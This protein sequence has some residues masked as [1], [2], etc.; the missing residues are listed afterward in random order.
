M[1]SIQVSPGQE[2]LESRTTSAKLVSIPWQLDHPVFALI[3]AI[4]QY[5]TKDMKLMGCVNDGKDFEAF[6]K[7]QLQVPS[8]NIRTLYDKEAT[9]SNILAG[10]N[11]YLIG[12]KNIKKDDLIFFF[13]AGH[14]DS[15][16][17]PEGWGSDKGK[18]EAIC[19]VDISAFETSNQF[20]ADLKY[21]IP[22]WTFHA[23]MRLLAHEKGNNIV[24]IFDCCHSGGLARGLP[25]LADSP[26]KSRSLL[27]CRDVPRRL[28]LPSNLDEELCSRGPQ[29]AETSGG[30]RTFVTPFGFA[31]SGSESHVLLA[32]CQTGEKA[33][34]HRPANLNID[35]GRFTFHLM[36]Y[37][38]ETTPQLAQSLTYAGLMEHVTRC[39][40]HGNSQPT[41]AQSTAVDGSS[42]QQPHCEGRYK[43]RILFSTGEAR[44]S[45][46]F[47][48]TYDHSARALYVAAG[49]I[50]G[51]I[52][53]D[54][55]TMTRFVCRQPATA[56]NS[57][58]T[59]ITLVPTKVGPFRTV[60]TIPDAVDGPPNA[61]AL[62][63]LHGLNA[64]VSSWGS[65]LMKV[66]I[67]GEIP[68]HIGSFSLVKT[69][70]SHHADIS[71]ESEPEG[72][73]GY[74][75]TRYDPL[76]S[77]FAKQTLALNGDDVRRDTV[78]H[79]IAKFNFNLYRHNPDIPVMDD[80]ELS[81][82]VQ[83]RPLQI[84]VH[85][86]T[87]QLRYE[88]EGSQDLFSNVERQII[89]ACPQSTYHVRGNGVKEAIIQA[90]EDK[91]YGLTL[92]TS[93]KSESQN[94]P[95]MSLFPYVFY[96]DPEDYSITRLYAPE[97]PKQAPLVRAQGQRYQLDIG[98]GA[99]STRCLQFPLPKGINKASAFLKIFVSTE[100]IDMDGLEQ[101]P[102]QSGDNR[103]PTFGPVDLGP[104]WSSSVYVLTTC[105]FG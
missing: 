70:P 100:Y 61:T 40:T 103:V 51:V 59:E 95:P 85:R 84:A 105:R 54:D 21:G 67:S 26:M 64:T 10:F 72:H 33:R 16:D 99:S 74:I 58:S 60:V 42:F 25:N 49:S 30:R 81:I 62:Q 4:D 6:L 1:A 82:E 104:G 43:Q 29:T 69:G 86:N 68:L 79:S 35:R 92:V 75:L 14:G 47:L 32:A 39:L 77:R 13:Y 7:E 34:E 31:Y 46:S 57:V 55:G 78:L 98:H 65:K 37:L 3:V 15:V 5:D 36:K 44:E 17:A 41:S 66:A 101:A 63:S 22:D 24:A 27:D 12:N 87:L 71:L 80:S 102:V 11:D 56:P 8:D 28:Q 96:F 20:E 89:S 91:C 38:R 76:M 53:N 18:V 83:L 73:G 48:I 50:H 23:L 93:C 97:N 94:S 88:P 45:N 90:S 52:N 2:L 19:P 9:R